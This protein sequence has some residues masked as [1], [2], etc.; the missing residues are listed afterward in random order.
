MRRLLALLLL[1]PAACIE[2]VEPPVATPTS[3][4]FLLHVMV[5]DS[6]ALAVHIQASLDPGRDAAGRRRAVTDS[7]ASVGPVLLRLRTTE[8]GPMLADTMLTGV[9]ATGFLAASNPAAVR[10]PVVH[11][12]P[13]GS[14]DA[15]LPRRTGAPAWAWDGDH[16]V[17][18]PGLGPTPGHDTQW[19]L[20]VRAH[21]APAISVQHVGSL[22]ADL[23]VHRAM[24]G[25]CQP[26]PVEAS[27]RY[28]QRSAFPILGEA[29]P[30]AVYSTYQIVW[31]PERSC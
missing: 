24:L 26:G 27:L 2:F 11:G 10:L 31:T 23:M 30:V 12:Y 9:A 20:H 3:P 15:W 16:L 14:L 1:V 7:T 5:L 6:G 22:P 18:S 13:P 19:V 28:Q 25:T 17:L 4:G 8:P 21:G 29:Y